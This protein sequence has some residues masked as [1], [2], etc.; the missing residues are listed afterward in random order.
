MNLVTFT[1][2]AY[3]GPALINGDETGLEDDESQHLSE[4]IHWLTSQGI[5]AEALDCSDES[6]FCWTHDAV[7]WT[8]GADCCTFTFQRVTDEAR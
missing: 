6:E 5:R 8:G 7:E 2:P 4:F 3:W 1:L